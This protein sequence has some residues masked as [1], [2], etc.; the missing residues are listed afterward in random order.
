MG[1]MGPYRKRRTPE[2]I[3]EREKDSVFR[4]IMRDRMER[5]EAI[6]REASSDN[7]SLTLR[8]LLPTE[9]P[10]AFGETWLGE[11]FRESDLRRIV[12][13]KFSALNDGKDYLEGR[14]IELTPGVSR[15]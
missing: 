10:G 7:L 1:M 3:E 12:A 13:L 4:W 8:K 2:E 15:R 9:K 11:I 14:A 5:D 6:V